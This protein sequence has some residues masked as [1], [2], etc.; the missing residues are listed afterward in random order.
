MVNYAKEWKQKIN[1]QQI[2]YN[3]FVSF[4][5]ENTIFSAKVDGMLGAFVYHQGDRSFFQTTTNKQIFDL[6]VIDEYEIM[7]NKINVKS[8][9]II[10]ELVAQAKGA[11]FPF[12]ETQS[13]VK[14][15]YKLENKDLVHHYPVDII[16]VDNQKYSY[17]QALSFLFKHIG[18]VGLPHI[19]LPETRKGDLD[20]FRRM[21]SVYEHKSGYDGIVARDVKGKNYKIKF[22]STVDVAIIGAGH[23][24]MP[25]WKKNQISYL[26]T[27][28]MDKDGIFRTSSKIGTGFKTP[29]RKMFYDYIMKNKLYEKNG[30]IFVQPQKVVEL[31]F[32]R[33]MIT[34]TPAYRFT[35]KKYVIV[36]KRKSITFSHP[37]LVRIRSDKVVDKQDVRLEQIPEFFLS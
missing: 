31:K 21:F 13:I 11:I 4:D 19:H 35:G 32:F 25:A 7:L 3:D 1:L 15:S 16:S 34:N 28:F 26:L 23:K 2:S 8:A 27:A 9:V 12:N 17:N 29:I 6:P 10:G 24:E 33:F 36:G 20:T 18:T 30:E 5:I 22:T 37:S 14:T